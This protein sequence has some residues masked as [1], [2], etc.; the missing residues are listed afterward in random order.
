MVSILLSV[1]LA[2][3]ITV[4]CL[5]FRSLWDLYL[6]FRSIRDLY[7]ARGMQL[8]I[9]RER[10]PHQRGAWRM[11]EMQGILGG[12]G[13]ARRL[14]LERLMTVFSTIE[15]CL[16]PL[17]IFLLVLAMK[18]DELRSMV[19]RGEDI[20]AL[21]SE[22]KDLRVQLAF[23]EDTR[24]RAIFD[25]TKAGMIQRACVQAQRTAESK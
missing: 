22:N 5:S 4:G 13:E 10:R 2:L 14:L 23:F 15:E 20:D 11:M 25:I 21:R 19:E 8:L 12:L 16:E 7:Q 1:P 18:V 6:P 3:E 24:A 9:A 17:F